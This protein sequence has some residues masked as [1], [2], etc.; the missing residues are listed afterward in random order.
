MGKNGYTKKAFEKLDKAYRQAL[1]KAAEI[2]KMTPLQVWKKL[3]QAGG[4][5]LEVL[6]SVTFESIENAGFKPM[7]AQRMAKLFRE[8]AGSTSKPA[9]KEAA[10][11]KP[12]DPESPEGFLS[13][14]GIGGGDNM[15]ALL[16]LMGGQ[17]GMGDTLT[18]L[19]DPVIFLPTYFKVVHSKPRHPAVGLLRG[20]YGTK[21][22]I[23]FDTATGNGSVEA[24]AQYMMELDKGFDEVAEGLYT[25]QDLTY[26]L[27]AVGDYPAHLEDMCPIT[28]KPLRTGVCSDTGIKWG[29]V[30]L[31]A[32]Q[33]VYIAVNMTREASVGHVDAQHRLFNIAS[34]GFDALAARY[35]RS[36]I[37]FD[38]L[39]ARD[40]LPTLRVEIG[41]RS[42]SSAPSASSTGADPFHRDDD[43][44]GHQR[45]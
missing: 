28:E 19:I 39:R 42:R 11:E 32:R 6:A 43:R 29:E 25:H 3:D 7:H 12:A 40:E 8:E 33:L 35:R 34:K 4:D 41:T 23:C 9:A 2:A 18:S 13:T 16:A 45:Y 1:E 27:F 31:S 17:G 21:R 36:K 24:T 10:A 30:E 37:R 26:K 20:A 14:L 15:V 38:E 5:S 44:T 22:V